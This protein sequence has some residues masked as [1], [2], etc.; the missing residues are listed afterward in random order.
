MVE[1]IEGDQCL[2]KNI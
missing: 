1:G 2:M